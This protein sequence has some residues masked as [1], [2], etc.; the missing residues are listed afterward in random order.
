MKRIY[1]ILF[2]ALPFIAQAQVT[3]LKN[4]NNSLSVQGSK[5]ETLVSFG[6]FVYYAATDGVTGIEL[7]RSDGTVA[8]TTRV[9]DIFPGDQDS[10]PGSLTVVGSFLY[11]VAN[12]GDHG[13]ELW[14]TDGTA[15]G[16]IL[17]SDINRGVASG[18]PSYLTNVNNTT[19]IF[20]AN[21][22]DHGQEIWK[23]DVATGT[24]TM[25]EDLNANGAIG[26]NPSFLTNVNGTVYFAATDDAVGTELYKTDGT[27]AVLVEDIASG[28]LSSEPHGLSAFNDKLL[29]IAEEAT[30]GPE[31]YVSNGTAASTFKLKTINSNG[32]GSFPT[33]FTT[34]GTF[35]YF[36]A[37]DNTQNELWRTDGSMAGTVMF[38]DI[39]TTSGSSSPKN[40]IVFNGFLY[41]NATGSVAS[42]T[43]LWKTNGVAAPT[44]AANINTQTNGHS[45]PMNFAVFNNALY[46]NAF[47]NAEG[48]ELYK[49]NGTSLS[50]VFDV[51]PGT[52][53]SG[54]KNLC[55]VGASN[56]FFAADDGTG[57]ELFK[58]NG[59]SVSQVVDLVSGSSGSDPAQLLPYSSSQ[60][61]F[62][63]DD[64]T[65]ADLW[66][67][68]GTTGGT[69]AFQAGGKIN[70]VGTASAN[71]NYMTLV[72]NTAYFRAMGS[73]ADVELYKYD[74]VNV[75][76]INVN[77]TGSS[78][79]LNLYALNST[80]LLFTAYTDAAGYELYKITN[81]SSTASLV[82]DINPG[83]SSSSPEGFVKYSAAPGF[84]YFRAETAAN[85]IELWRTDGTTANTTLV[86]DIEAGAAHGVPQYITELNGNLY[87]EANRASVGG[88][89]LF[90]WNGTAISLVKDIHPTSQSQ[91]ILLTVF[92]G[93][94]YFNAKSSGTSNYELF[95]MDGSNEKVGLVKEIN[96]D[97]SAGSS[98]NN[99]TIF[100]SK[101]HRE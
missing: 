23:T 22:G 71:I 24:T 48:Q 27:T 74:G 93:D 45:N 70:T 86:A 31:P 34:L 76:K 51:L 95:K 39:N 2:F 12:D 5:P 32:V 79:V 84:V 78:N 21:D 18:N 28:T 36:G 87:F 91:P 72:G 97:A 85:G 3:L 25:I 75:T 9:R 89:E 60:I 6:G 52:A 59:T 41:F 67:T 54:P 65:G 100:N 64:G 33:N 61:I 19:V 35:A 40:F 15:K 56:L 30:N 80:T 68:D 49:Y 94:L 29:F 66:K 1:L 88:Y 69:V 10:K 20:G 83:V 90:K 17:V 11:F 58:Y 96:P 55:G 57:Q 53:G 99:F 44:I 7:W 26:S 38:A 101:L 77:V 50:P 37:S 98:V 62:S 92:N 73:D 42:G 16:T 43:E 46:F 82:K 81:G 8:G 4:I 63:A 13:V 47:T 14:R